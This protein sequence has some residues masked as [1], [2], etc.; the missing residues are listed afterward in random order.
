[1]TKDEE[2]SK[3]IHSLITGGKGC[4]HEA[5]LDDT[6]VVFTCIHCHEVV[7][8]E[9]DP[10]PDYLN[11]KSDAYDLIQ[12][13]VNKWSDE[14]YYNFILSVQQDEPDYNEYSFPRH[15]LKDRRALPEALAR[16]EKENG[17]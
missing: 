7:D 10:N 9:P 3:S 1:M 12:F 14:E 11:S 17:E 4:W 8:I 13:V 15:L 6:W 2:I 16:Y 5:R